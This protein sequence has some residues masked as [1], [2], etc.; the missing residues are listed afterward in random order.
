MRRGPQEEEIE[1]LDFL[2]DANVPALLVATKL[3]RE[4]KSKQKSTLDK[5]RKSTGVNV[6]GTSA[7]D[8]KGLDQLSK[9]AFFHIQFY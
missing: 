5:L 9:S 2:A 6:I 1:L 4:K 3:D 8:R 7:A